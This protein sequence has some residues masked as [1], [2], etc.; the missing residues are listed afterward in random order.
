MGANFNRARVLA[1]PLVLAGVLLA[2]PQTAR[3]APAEDPLSG[4][5]MMKATVVQERG[6]QKL[7]VG[8]DI[9]AESKAAIGNVKA[10]DVPGTK[11]RFATW[12]EQLGDDSTNYYAIKVE[13][14]AWT[15][16]KKTSYKILLK[17][18]AFDP[19]EKARKPVPAALE[20]GPKARLFLVQFATQGLEAYR[21]TIRELGAEVH[22]YI[23]NHCHIVRM[24]PEIAQKV[25]KLPFVRWVG[26]M[27]PAFKLDRALLAKRAKEGEVG[28]YNVMVVAKKDKDSLGGAIQ[29]IGGKIVH[30]NRGSILL[31]A[32]LNPQQVEQVAQ[33]DWVQWVDRW[34]PIEEDMNNARRQGGADHIETVPPGY[35]GIGIRGHVLEG[36][37][38]EHPDFAANAHRVAPIIVDDGTPSGHGQNTFGEVFGDGTH[39]PESHARGLLPNAQGLYTNYN[40]VYAAAPGSQ[41]PG[42]RYELVGRLIQQHQVMFQTASWGYG[43]TMQY[44][45]RSAEMD[46]LIF[47]HDIPITQSQSNAGNQMSRPQAWA[48]NIISV[49]GAYHYDDYD[50]SNDKWN[51]PTDPDSA[52]IGPASDD[53]IKPDL[54]AFFDLTRTTDGSSGYTSHFGGTSGATPIIAGHVGLCLEM[55][56]NAVFGNSLPQPGGSRFDNR[57]HFTTT[58]AL[59]ICSARQYEF[60]GTT[61]DLTRTHQGWGFPDL[62]RLHQYKDKVLVVNE[63]DVLENLQNKTYEVRVAAGEPLL[64]IT[65][66]YADPAGSPTA[67]QQRINNLDLKVTDPAGGVYWGNHGLME[68]RFSAPGGS[69]NVLDT[70]ENVFI[71]NPAAGIWKVDVIADELNVDAHRETAGVVDADYALVVLGV[72]E[73]DPSPRLAYLG[74]R[75]NHHLAGDTGTGLYCWRGKRWLVNLV[76]DRTDTKHWFYY[77]KEYPD[78]R[79]AFAKKAT[80]CRGFAVWFKPD[81]ETNN[82]WI[83]YQY[84]CRVK[85]VNAD[86]QAAKSRGG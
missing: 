34:T 71:E 36:I 46:D 13:G 49:G 6:L 70:V 29:K 76:Y 42:S 56:T 5:R 43:R 64:K 28:R 41:A 44:D 83:L 75:G 40:A 20:S 19:L 60:S 35:T 84:A 74:C 53:R 1:L 58:K 31:V 23:P 3:T 32:E 25:A 38:R 7:V 47:D 68:G 61:H 21:R 62:K 86:P 48:K 52:S 12:V 14:R 16:P 11:I 51:D 54:C 57:P 33:L 39:D 72:A 24:D 63:D 4:G 45:P 8:G 22:N 65:M 15:A 85:P 17:Q 50:P 77:E 9:V 55:W 27:H 69:P 67:S 18:G 10:A 59:L 30:P 26:P 66:V 2:W 78:Y 73:K 82:Q 81:G 79:W 80:S 37:Y